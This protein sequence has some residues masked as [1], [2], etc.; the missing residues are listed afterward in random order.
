MKNFLPLIPHGRYAEVAL[1]ESMKP[2]EEKLNRTAMGLV[3]QTSVPLYCTKVVYFLSY[4]SAAKIEGKQVD[5]SYE[6]EGKALIT[7]TNSQNKNGGT[8]Q[9]ELAG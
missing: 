6:F 8:V 7:G 5:A 2:E 3:M 4:G 1:E 9:Q